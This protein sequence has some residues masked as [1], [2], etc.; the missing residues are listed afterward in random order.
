MSDQ[1]TNDSH[2][3]RSIGAAPLY[4]TPPFTPED[5][6]YHVLQGRRMRAQMAGELFRKGIA[7]LARVIGYPVRVIGYGSGKAKVAP[8]HRTELRSQ[9]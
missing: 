8:V 3:K 9:H 2:A 5:I 4:E 6:D 7:G 1:Y